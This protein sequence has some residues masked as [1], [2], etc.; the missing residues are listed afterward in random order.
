M[1]IKKNNIILNNIMLNDYIDCCISSNGSHYD[2]SLVIYEIIKNNF[3]YI[4]NN[5]W[6]YKKDGEWIIDEKNINLR[7]EIKTNVI[8][9]FLERS[10]YWINKSLDENNIDKN[11]EFDNNLKSLKLLQVSNKL[12]DDKFISNIIKETKQFYE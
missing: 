5:I 10:K 11:I 1:Y 3:K 12:T 6:N 7:Q 9:H 4:G 8:N 2:I